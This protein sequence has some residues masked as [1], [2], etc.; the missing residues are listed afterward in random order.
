VEALVATVYFDVTDIV[1]FASR[2]SRVTG[3]QRVQLNII[4]LLAQK[5]GG[6]TVRCTFF[7]AVDHTM[8]EFDPAQLSTNRE[9]DAE[10]FLT[11]LGRGSASTWLPSKGQVK[12]YLRRYSHRKW[13]RTL[14]KI[15]IYF[16]AVFIPSRLRAR[17][18]LTNRRSQGQG[19]VALKTIARLPDKSTY[20]CMGSV[21]LH[22]EVL[23]FGQR[24]SASGQEVVQMVYDLIPIVHPEYYSAKEAQAY[25]TWLDDAFNYVSRFI[26]ISKWT[27]A[28][29]QKYATAKGHRPLVQAIPLAHEF[30][31]FDR[32]SKIETPAALS[33][34]SA[35]S[36]VLCVGTIESRKN[37][38][39]LLQSWQR[40]ASELGER[41][42][43]LVFA[44]K[45]GK[46]SEQFQQLLA[47]DPKLNQLVSV[48]HAPS[49]R[50]LAWLY[51]NCLFTV[52]PSTYEGWGLPVGESIWF[53]KY[54]V[55]S[56][57]TSVPEVCG[58]LLDYVDPDNLTSICAGL[59]RALID[60]EFLRQR[61][62]AIAAV[63]P[64]RWSDVAE[65]IYSFLST[66]ISRAANL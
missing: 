14:V 60:G 32:D 34:L 18:L 57:A 20:V 64:R 58:E 26:C 15:D 55:A 41:M 1:N 13:L 50:E 8:L 24:H 37:G 49:D 30:F 2:Y 19:L 62:Q 7:D 61:E 4:T 65:D 59:R 12:S 54:C 22:R 40:L 48:I 21:W 9:F 56:R 28:D 27:A 44:G 46:G 3:I 11:D 23:E 31:G 66:S 53:G 10:C 38:V 29:L 36:F 47:K 42:P 17:G 35:A 16:S 39:A 6:A 5:H 51:Q 25:A 43:R 45:Y 33:E 63:K 52:F